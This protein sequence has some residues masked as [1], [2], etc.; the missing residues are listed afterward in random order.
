MPRDQMGLVKGR[1]NELRNVAAK[2]LDAQA[3]AAKVEIERAETALLGELAAAALTTDEAKAWLE[4]LP[5]IAELMPRL[6]LVELEAEV[7]Q[8]HALVRG[9]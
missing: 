6:R 7:D 3:K 4:R 1:R 8:Q 9:W 2:R 5:S